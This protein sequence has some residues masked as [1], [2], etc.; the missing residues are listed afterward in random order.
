M[1]GAHR[2]RAELGV[3]LVVV[4]LLGLLVLTTQRVAA[5]CVG[6]TLSVTP[7]SARPGEQVTVRGQY[8]GD[9]CNDT[10]GSGPVLGNAIQDI[11]IGIAAP[12]WTLV[13]TVDADGDYAF[14]VVVTVPRSASGPGAVTAAG[15][16]LVT[17]APISVHGDA[18]PG[19]D[20][21]PVVATAEGE[22]SI[23]GRFEG[24][25]SSALM[26][27]ALVVV[28]ALAAAAVGIGVIGRRRSPST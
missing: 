7:T 20:P 3:A 26:V 15:A 11:E 21:P 19:T 17:Q 24:G 1:R 8:F 27:A 4:T 22:P 9:D 23:S 28:G 10:G 14:E 13:A 18:L 12:E 16:L 2:G 6:S 5:S 25:T